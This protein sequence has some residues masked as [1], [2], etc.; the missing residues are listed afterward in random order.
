VRAYQES[1][2]D[3][4]VDG[5]VGPA[6]LASIARDL[7]ARRLASAAG[8]A[9]AGAG[10]ASAVASGAAGA[11]HPLLLAGLVAVAVLALVAGFLVWR[12][13][14]ELRRLLTSRKGT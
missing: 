2:P 6:T 1:H 4:V 8:A 5:I 3:L 11:A 14:A 7:A 12:Y 10:A 13:G 9:A